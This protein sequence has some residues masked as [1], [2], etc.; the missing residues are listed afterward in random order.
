VTIPLDGL[1]HL[2]SLPV[3]G[4]RRRR[5]PVS[6][7]EA[8]LLSTP[9]SAWRGRAVGGVQ[10]FPRRHHRKIPGHQLRFTERSRIDSSGRNTSAAE[11]LRWH[12]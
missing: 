1:L 5:L 10:A 3:K 7:E 9:E 11:M 6:P 8:L 4:L 12:R 2:R